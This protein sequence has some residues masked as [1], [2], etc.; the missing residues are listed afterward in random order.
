MSRDKLLKTEENVDYHL[1]VMV[2][3]RETHLQVLKPLGVVVL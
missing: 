2:W 3:V 1:T